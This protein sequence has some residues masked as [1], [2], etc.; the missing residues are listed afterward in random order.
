MEESPVD[1]QGRLDLVGVLLR[2]PPPPPF[3]LI[4]PILQWLTHPRLDLPRLLLVLRRLL[5]PLLDLDLADV[6][7]QILR[8]RPRYQ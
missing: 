3:P 6:D 2:S 5:F 8:S 1:A 4:T 7:D